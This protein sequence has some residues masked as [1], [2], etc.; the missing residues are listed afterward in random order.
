MLES[1]TLRDSAFMFSEPYPQPI[2][3]MRK[4]GW[5]L[6]KEDKTSKTNLKNCWAEIEISERLN[7]YV[8]DLD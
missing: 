3:Y 8:R 7:P 4:I 2:C 6:G 1:I 5:A